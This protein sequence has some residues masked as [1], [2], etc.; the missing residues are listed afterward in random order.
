MLLI[1]LLIFMAMPRSS[2]G[3]NGESGQ[4]IHAYATYY[5]A[6][7]DPTSLVG[8][9]GYDDTLR[10]GFGLNTA[11]LSGAL[12]QMGQACGACYEITCHAAA[13]PLWCLHGATVTVTA[14]NFCPP[15]NGGGDGWCN[16]PRRHFDMS[17]PSFA[18][19]ARLGNEGIVPI[20]YRRV[21]CKRSGGV[22]FT[23]RGQ[24]NF[25]L[26]LFS[27]VGGSGDVRAAWIKGS[28]T[29]TTTWSPMQRNW[30]ANWQTAAD[31]RRQT[32]SFRLLL[33]D[34][35]TLEFAGVVPATWAPGQSFVAKAQFS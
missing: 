3:I 9:C 17:L 28:M 23:L 25:N 14:T 13:D 16:P 18:R 4:W 7:Q 34:G 26:V 24:G 33:G 6:N 32:L 1:S 19:I 15:N 27:N 5:G 30:G 31:Y 8:A 10:A 22:R 2:D 35:R 21:G 20:L 29:T 11:A 12:F